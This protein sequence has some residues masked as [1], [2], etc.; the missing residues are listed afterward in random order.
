MRRVTASIPTTPRR[1]ALDEP[2]AGRADGGGALLE[3]VDPAWIGAGFVVLAAAVYILSN[4]ERHG[5]YDHFVWQA[6]AWLEGRAAITYPVTGEFRNDYFQD[7]YP[8]PDQP[9]YALI[10]FPPL[11]AIVLL[12]FVA[13]FGLATDAGL[14]A[15]VLGAINVGLCWRMVG[16][17][18]DRRDAA[19]L[20]TTFYAFGTVAWYAAMLGTTW[21]LA[22]VCAST[23]L[24]IAITAALDGETRERARGS[25]R[26]LAGWIEPRQF[27]A[28]LLLGIGSLARLPVAF[29]AP[30]FMLV[31][32]GGSVLRRTVSAGLGGIIPVALLIG[33]NLAVT[34]HVFHPAY[35]YLYRTEYRPL[36]ELYHPDW[37]IEDPRYIPQNAAIMLLWP[38]TVPPEREQR[39]CD[40]DPATGP[41]GA[42][43]YAP[44][45]GLG[46]L[47]D[48]HCALIRPD[49]IGL[50]LIASS[51]AY[52]LAI[53]ALLARWRR[54]H[55]AGAALA[56]LA[57]ATLNLMHFSQGWVQFG[58][59]F[60][61]DFAPFALI[62]VA[63]GIAL[64]RRRW[65]AV[66]LV[67]LSVAINA[68]GVYW[69]V[70]LGW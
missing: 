54:R 34:G 20:A 46:L 68:W 16:R 45:T 27:A 33:Y 62:P 30:F 52:L 39:Q 10:P 36:P 64:V 37:A 22:H 21:F 48:E 67:G 12:P 19:L 51:P 8:L 11:P 7:V 4:P 60:S 18:T 49:P 26:L 24:F 41:A 55:V 43:E 47:F 63:V 50:S 65:L 5:F 23:F 56:L 14:V 66:L 61:N 38:P 3:R 53:P 28:G 70:Q 57:L 6:A 42:P 2:A 69:G 44:P 25:V 35:E 13:L 32:G 59:R 1:A 17:V 29:G 58:Y 9:G 31:G 40:G 15:A